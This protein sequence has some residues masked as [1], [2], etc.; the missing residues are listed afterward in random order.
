MKASE[1][2]VHNYKSMCSEIKECLLKLDEKVTFLIGANESGKTNTLEAMWKF[3]VGEFENDD[4]PQRCEWHG[5][6]DIPDDLPMVSVT[7]EIEDK[8]RGKLNEIHPALSKTN[9]VTI[10]RNYKGEPYIK[11]PDLKAEAGVDKITSNIKEIFDKFANNFR[12][13]AKKYRKVNR[14]QASSTLSASKRLKSLGDQI[15]GLVESFDV[16]KISPTRKRIKRLRGAVKELANPLES[17]DVEVYLPLDEIEK[18]VEQLLKSSDAMR[19]SQKLCEIIPSFLFVPADPNLWL[20][21]EYWVDDLIREPESEELASVK[22]LLMLSGLNLEATRSL[23]DEVQRS[24]LEDASKK[25]TEVLREVWKQEEDVKIKLDWSSAEGNKKLLVMVDSTGHC[26]F[27]ESRSYGFRWFLEFYLLHAV[28]MKSNTILLFEEPGIHLHPDAQQ[29]LKRFIRDQVAKESQVVY[30]TH[31]PDMYDMTYPEGCRAVEKDLKQGGVTIVQTQ[32]SPH[33]QHATWEVAMRAA[34]VSSPALRVYDRSII[35]EGPGDWIFLLTFAQILTREDPRLSDLACSF[36]HIRH[37]Q[38]TGGILKHVSFHFQPGAKSV[39]LLDS[40]VPGETLRGKLESEV[41][42]PNEFVTK[43]LMINDIKKEDG[44]SILGTGHHELE[45][46]IG[47]RYYAKLVTGTLGK[48]N[49]ISAAN[50]KDENMIGAQAVKIAKKKYNIDLRKDDVAWHFRKLAKTGNEK[51]PAEVK[52]NFKLL[53]LQTV[54][55]L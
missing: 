12:N 53:L 45:D 9:D 35:V 34:G 28:A 36:I 54:E 51:I 5:K 16:S 46:L 17:V 24:K 30:T 29:Y 1:V 8:D 27:P 21:G 10:T 37:Y 43:I 22:R 40:D 23:K 31:M 32:Y 14:G 39:I 18:I 4:I 38:G 20:K 55:H 3:S 44:N 49:K 47:K 33:S 13:Y 26:G 48:M 7:F 19:A 41:G 11:Y 2:Y 6:T 50:F 25:I 52:N 42:L 15:D